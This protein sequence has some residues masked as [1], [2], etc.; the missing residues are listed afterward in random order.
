MYADEGCLQH[1]LLIYLFIHLFINALFTA[2]VLKVFRT[3]GPTAW[4]KMPSV[5]K[6][7]QIEKKIHD[8]TWAAS[9]LNSYRSLPGSQDNFLLC[10]IDTG[11]QGT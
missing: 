8:W 7:L 5:F 2:Q 1:C 11:Y 3:P 4:L 9:I 10:I 6:K